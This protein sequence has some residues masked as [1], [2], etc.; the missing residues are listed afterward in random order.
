MDAPF[1]YVGEVHT[2]PLNKGDDSTPSEKDK[3]SAMGTY[4]SFYAIEAIKKTNTSNL[5]KVTPTGESTNE[6][7][8]TVPMPKSKEDP[9]GISTRLASD[10]IQ[11]WLMNRPI[12]HF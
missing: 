1:Y 5:F 12:T 10:A 9:T 8:G 6:S 4:A 7:V 2:H 11:S 3:E